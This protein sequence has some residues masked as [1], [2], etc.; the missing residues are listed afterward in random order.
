MFLVRPYLSGGRGD[1]SGARAG[2]APVVCRARSVS[3]LCLAGV[4]GE[5]GTQR[6]SPSPPSMFL[7]DFSGRP[8]FSQPPPRDKGAPAKTLE[9]G[10]RCSEKSK[11]NERV[12]TRG[13][14][15][16]TSNFSGGCW[17]KQMLAGFWV[18]HTMDSP[19]RLC[20]GGGLLEPVRPTMINQ[21]SSSPSSSSVFTSV[22]SSSS[23]SSSSSAEG[24]RKGSD[25]EP[26]A[27]AA[28][29]SASGLEPRRVA[30]EEAE[31]QHIRDRLARDL[32]PAYP[33]GAHV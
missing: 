14:W 20:V 33:R 2:L 30:A 31:P 21:Y 19:D 9:G 7:L 12:V 6:K 1:G 26:C 29:L 13:V 17:R 23:S 24:C 32:Q 18:G 28:L 27:S 15:C 5:G 8:R 11:K 4:T 22:P 16:I 10:E 25:V 3:P